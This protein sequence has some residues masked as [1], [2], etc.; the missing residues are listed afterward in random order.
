M[1]L[2]GVVVAHL[3]A[4]FVLPA[5]HV[6][7]CSIAADVQADFTMHLGRSGEAYFLG[8]DDVAGEYIGL[9]FCTDAQCQHR[10]C[11]GQVTR[12]RRGSCWQE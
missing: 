9:F 7:V 5:L 4:A 11:D 3:P 2:V 6:S 8:E 10:V 1:W 12:M